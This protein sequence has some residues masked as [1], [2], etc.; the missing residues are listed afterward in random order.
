MGT[1]S[2]TPDTRPPASHLPRQAGAQG[3]IC[4]IDRFDIGTKCL[5]EGHGSEWQ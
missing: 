4:S 2:E 5:P 3:N 1:E